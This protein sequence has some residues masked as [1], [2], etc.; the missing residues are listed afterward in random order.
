MYDVFRLEPTYGSVK[1]FFIMKK[2]YSFIFLFAMG[3]SLNAQKIL[4]IGDSITDGKW[5]YECDGTRNTDDMNH[6]FGHGY[7]YLIAAKYMAVYPDSAMQFYNRGISGNTVKDLAERWDSD[8]LSVNPDVLS[9][10]IGINDVLNDNPSV[11][12]VAFEKMYRE[13]LTK[14][15]TQNPNLVILLG[16][17]FCENG[18]R[19]DSEGVIRKKCEALSRAVQRIANDFDARFIPY[20][21]FFDKLCKESSN[22]SYW[23][24]DGVHPTPAGHYKMSVLWEQYLPTKK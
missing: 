11:D 12:T 3:I 21:A 8:V 15:R 4:F 14:S 7:M 10:L 5:G 9:V 6:I 20:Q 1:G 24:W 19:V 2:I 23:I 22:T 13:I 17:P 16:E 18:F